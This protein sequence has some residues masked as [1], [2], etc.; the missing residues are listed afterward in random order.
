MSSYYS[1]PQVELLLK[2][3][4]E[5]NPGL[6]ELRD[7][8]NTR[9]GVPFVRTPAAGEIQNTS[10][11]LYAQPGS[12][13]IGKKIVHYRRIDLSKLFAN[14]TLDIEYW[15][16]GNLPKATWIDLINKKYGLALVDADMAGY[17]DMGETTYVLNLA[18]TSLGYNGTLRVRWTRGKRAMDQILT[19]DRY[20]G[21]YWD[22][23]YVQ[24]K[25]LMTPVN[26]SLDYSRFF[27]IDTITN[28]ITLNNAGAYYSEIKTIVDWFNKCAGLALDLGVDHTL[29]NGLKGLTMSRF[30]L[31]NVNVPEANAAKFNRV[32]VISSRT[33]SWFG[34]KILLHYNV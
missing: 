10:L 23:S 34:G 15:A 9:L 1:K 17:G 19:V 22:S 28:G 26:F 32:L 7:L 16:P 3:I 4:N 21:L 24:G 8:V 30:T 29:P 6:L 14:M 5:S 25:P 31:P 11:E 18:G 12:F 13:Y 33:T 2:L 20:A 27:N